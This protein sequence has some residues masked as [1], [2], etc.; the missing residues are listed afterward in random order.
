M[1]NIGIG[2]SLKSFYSSVDAAMFAQVR[3]G[4]LVSLNITECVVE[5]VPLGERVCLLNLR[6]QERSLCVL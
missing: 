3:V 5:R 2:T 1:L 4:L 6:L